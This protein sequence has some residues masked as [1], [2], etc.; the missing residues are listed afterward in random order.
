MRLKNKHVL[1]FTSH[2]IN[3]HLFDVQYAFFRYSFMMDIYISLYIITFYMKCVIMISTLLKHLFFF[4][5][6]IILI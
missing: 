6:K 4:T 2:D 3:D 1:I 5:Q